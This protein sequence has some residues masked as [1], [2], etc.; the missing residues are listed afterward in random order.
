MRERRP[1][2]HRNLD[3]DRL[4]RDVVKGA[5][6]RK[7]I[8]QPRIGCWLHDKLF[9]H[10][11]LPAPYEGMTLPEI[12]RSLGCSARIYEYNECF[13]KI[14]DPRAR[15]TVRES[16][17]ITTYVYETPVGKTTHITE[18]VKTSWYPLIKKRWVTSEDELKVISWVEEHCQWDY[19]TG[20]FQ[21]VQA[22]W[23]GLGAPT[24]F[25]PRVNIQNLYIDLMGVAET[26]NA[27]IDYPE[28]VERYFQILGESHERLILALN[29]SPVDII[30]YGDNVHASTLSPTLFKKYVLPVYHRRNELLHAAG[31]FTCAH[32][33]GDTKPLLPYA[34]ETGL[35]GIEAITPQPQGDVTIE[36][37]KQGLGND[38]FLLDGIAATLFDDRFPLK[39]LE[40]QTKKVIEYFA[41]RLILGIS[42]E[43][44]STGNLERI[45]FV[46]DIVDD[47]NASVSI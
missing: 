38:M 11:K 17:G 18:R 42:D 22:L 31:K 21:K 12:Y 2:D 5:S 1:T 4:H 44:S 29:Q 10:Q 43:I 34:R 27:L 32:W 9:A 28:T 36:E 39:A 30:N 47:Y 25:M 41:P 37:M 7:I 16:D 14:D 8:W 13:R 3:L 40:E 45:R 20:V 35:D 19:D 46:G 15:F 24:M 33:D 23:G 26:I 6:G